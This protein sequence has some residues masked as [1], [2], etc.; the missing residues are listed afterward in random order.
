MGKKNHYPENVREKVLVLN[1]EPFREE[2]GRMMECSPTDA[3]IRAFAKRHPDK[4]YGMMRNV[5]A[6][7]GY[8][9][10]TANTETNIYMQI[11]TL[12]D[13]QLNDELQHTLKQLGKIQGE[14]VEGEVI[15][16]G[17]SLA[18]TD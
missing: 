16:E 10:K 1:R 18:D 3:N 4:F 15:E 2:L 9:D 14:T 17:P 7:A 11:N 8:H 5:A 6:L 12:P 13:S